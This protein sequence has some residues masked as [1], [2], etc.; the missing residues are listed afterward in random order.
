MPD[1]KLNSAIPPDFAVASVWRTTSTF[2]ASSS[3]TLKQRRS[4]RISS[5]HTITLLSSPQIPDIPF[6]LSL[7]IARKHVIKPCQS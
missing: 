4:L 1:R 5:G 2:I 6:T 3:S 7:T